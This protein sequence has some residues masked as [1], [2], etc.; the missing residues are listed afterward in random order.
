MRWTR[1]SGAADGDGGADPGHMAASASGGLGEGGADPGAGLRWPAGGSLRRT[2]RYVSVALLSRLPLH[3]GCAPLGAPAL[4]SGLRERS[5]GGRIGTGG[6]LPPHPAA[7]TC[8]AGGVDRLCLPPPRPPAPA[9]RLRALGGACTSFGASGTFRWG[10]IGTGGC[11]P[12]HPA[13]CPCIAR[14]GGSAA[15]STSSAGGPCIPAARPWGRL[16]FVRGF[17]NVPVGG[18]S[19]PG[20]ASRPIRRPAPASRGGWIGCAFHLLG[21]LPLHPG[22]AP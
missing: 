19:A 16:H 8:I 21:R 14:G 1:A 7:C 12:P 6:C 4:R 20:G 15:P 5:G 17:G 9:S 13:V 11:L 22:C 2:F 10:R 18:G 3:P